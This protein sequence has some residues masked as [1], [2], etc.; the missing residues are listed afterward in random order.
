MGEQASDVDTEL[1]QVAP[2]PRLPKTSK[3]I[4]WGDAQMQLFDPDEPATRRLQRDH[5]DNALPRGTV[6][7][8]WVGA[9]AAGH[10]IQKDVDGQNTR[11]SLL[12]FGHIHKVP[13][14]Q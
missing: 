1:I 8:A 4:S 12:V 14:L 10:F 13:G 7:Q 6:S 9:C 5:N 11:A 3:Q 2:R